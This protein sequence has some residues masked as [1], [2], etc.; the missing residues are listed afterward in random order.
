M[1]TDTF[2]RVQERRR[3]HLVTLLGE[4][5]IGKTR[6]VEEFRDGLGDEVTVLSG[7]P[8]QFE[9]QVTFWPLGQMIRNAVDGGGYVPTEELEDRLRA[10]GDR[11]GGP[12][13][14][15]QGRAPAGSGARPG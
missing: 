7:R 6:V 11:V 4:P 10:G 5:G 9:E 8:S 2:E 12:G 13:G 1:L 15:R 14:R 3:A